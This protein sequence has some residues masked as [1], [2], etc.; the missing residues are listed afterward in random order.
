VPGA[1]VPG[2]AVTVKDA[3]AAADTEPL[4]DE[5]CNQFPPVEVEAAAVY[6]VEVMPWLEM[7]N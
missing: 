1:S 4:L 3:G 6:R 7:V 5:I 2:F